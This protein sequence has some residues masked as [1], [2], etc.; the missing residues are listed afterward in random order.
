M[1]DR[2]ADGWP[3]ILTLKQDLIVNGLVRL[4]ESDSI[5]V[6]DRNYVDISLIE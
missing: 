5:W 1:I 2:V 6:K 4:N 3:L